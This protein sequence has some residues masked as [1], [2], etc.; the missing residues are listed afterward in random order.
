MGTVW[1]FQNKIKSDQKY[2]WIVQSVT[3]LSVWWKQKALIYFSVYCS[4]Q[5]CRREFFSIKR[6]CSKMQRMP[7]WF[8]PFFN[9]LV[10]PKSKTCGSIFLWYFFLEE[11]VVDLLCRLFICLSCCCVAAVAEFRFPHIFYHGLKT[12][13]NFTSQY[14]LECESV[15]FDN[16]SLFS[17]MT[18]LVPSLKIT[19]QHYAGAPLGL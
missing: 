7:S 14:S 3:T 2:Q 5:L 17:P 18:L 4:A 10:L 13:D 1:K 8:D 9:Q 15:L 6:K 19:L 11:V 12:F 16:L